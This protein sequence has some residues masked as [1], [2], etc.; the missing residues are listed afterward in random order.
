MSYERW[1]IVGEGGQELLQ[2]SMEEDRITIRTG[3][4]SGFM[5]KPEG[6]HEPPIN[7]PREH[8]EALAQILRDSTL[9]EFR[10]AKV[11]RA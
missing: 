4:P 8:A 7:L 1:K 10:K 2:C 5:T 11:V 9:T 6:G 3:P